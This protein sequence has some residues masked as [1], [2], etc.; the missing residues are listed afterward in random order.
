[1]DS[2][3]VPS[4]RAPLTALAKPG[5]ALVAELLRE[6]GEASLVKRENLIAQAIMLELDAGVRA[7]L[8]NPDRSINRAELERV[9]EG[10]LRGIFT[11]KFAEKLGDATLLEGVKDTITTAQLQMALA[12]TRQVR[13]DAKAIRAG[14]DAVSVGM[15]VV[16][17]Q[18]NRL[19][20]EAVAANRT[21]GA[22]ARESLPAHAL[23]ALNSQD[24][25]ALRLSSTEIVTLAGRAQ[26]DAIRAD[27]ARVSDALSGVSQAFSL[28]PGLEREAAMFSLGS[29]VVDDL[30]GLSASLATTD[31]L[32]A[33]TS[34]VSLVGRI[35]GF[36][37]RK[38]PSAEER[39]LHQVFKEMRELSAKIDRYHQ[40]EMA[41]L[42]EINQRLVALNREM[43]RG[44][45]GLRDD[46]GVVSRGV[47]E[48]LTRDITG[49]KDLADQY[50]QRA[51]SGGLDSR[52]GMARWFDNDG[53]GRTW[54]S[55]IDELH[56]VLD[57]KSE[58]SFST[59]L[60]ERSSENSDAV[61]ED[62]QKRVRDIEYWVLQPTIL[63]MRRHDERTPRGYS[64]SSIVF[65]PSTSICTPGRIESH[66]FCIPE[67][68]LGWRTTQLP[69]SQ[70]N[71]ADGRMLWDR[72]IIEFVDYAKFLAPLNTSVWEDYGRGGQPRVISR[73]ELGRFS[74]NF[75]A[76]RT[77]HLELTLRSIAA[78]DLL[79]A[80]ANVI[81]GLPM[82]ERAS[83]LVDEQIIPEY[84]KA[85]LLGESSTL[86]AIL[87][88]GSMADDPTDGPRCAT[89]EFAFDTLCL[90]QSNR[91]F[92]DNVLRLVLL[93]RL[94][95][96]G[97]TWDDWVRAARLPFSPGV[98]TLIG[99]DILLR[100]ASLDTDGAVHPRWAIELPKV[101]QRSED[102]ARA[103]TNCWTPTGAT[104]PRDGTHA[105]QDN[106][107]C[108]L[109]P[110]PA[111]ARPDAIASYFDIE[112]VVHERLS[113]QRQ[114][115]NDCRALDYSDLVCGWA[116]AS[117]EVGGIRSVN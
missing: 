31:Y 46:V 35:A 3:E 8:L 105:W 59:A 14:L 82:V 10:E 61:F 101:N 92:R 117:V 4:G 25:N 18:Q 110:S 40:Q 39:M 5:K 98:S 108:A 23:L 29:G 21:L 47:D 79:L 66:A 50:L 19:L 24:P 51:I 70:F 17:D 84:A 96:R 102:S 87:T 63:Y 45:L 43:R 86:I 33:A 77:R 99:A 42:D 20:D 88:R 11:P 81:A 12:D 68:V 75:F 109:L 48:L 1:L 2:I 27:A 30:G 57:V 100:D 41:L 15:N 53:R 54:V 93:R 13:L 78:L 16:R 114:L 90:M 104:V 67:P 37:K 26:A 32:G 38:G 9:L 106:A 83:A 76:E 71:V 103:P 91:W 94:K 60:L 72:R 6:L 85:R 49:C 73:E 34:A 74:R 28:I 36:G 55:C 44:I 65:E 58:T 89:G 113:R 22:I 62:R 107:F 95:A 7:T 97:K 69:N 52:L 64:S 111:D 80:Q 115:E 116:R 112:V 56:R